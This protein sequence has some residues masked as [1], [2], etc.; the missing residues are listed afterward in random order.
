MDPFL[1][2][3]CGLII[4]LV[5]L[6]LGAH[7]G[8]AL[9]VSGFLGLWYV[10][11]F[12]RAFIM[13]VSSIYGKV[14]GTALVTLPL[15][16]LVGFLASGGGISENIYKSLDMMIGRFKSGLG[17]ATVGAC[18]A[19]GTVCGS[20]LVTAA[21]FAKISAPEMRR[22][23][24]S[25]GLAY[26]I[27]AASGSIGM[28]IPP[29]I[30]AI[31]YGMLSGVS[32]GKL[33]IAG[34]V[35]G[36]LWAVLFSITIPIVARV[37]PTSIVTTDEDIPTYTLWEK[38]KSL[39]LWWPVFASGAIIFGGI[40]GGVFTP[41]EASAVAAF[42]L[43]VYYLYR[44]LFSK[45][46]AE[47]SG[48]EKFD[49]LKEILTNTATTSAMIFFVF[50]AATIFSHFALMT[51]LASKLMTFVI[52]LKL[53]KLSLIIFF[54]VIYLLLG[55]LM[56][57]ISMLCITISLFNPIIAKAGIDPIWYAIV[58][59]LAIEV[60]F[61][62]PPFGINLYSVLGVAEKDVDIKDLIVGSFPFFIA[63]MISLVLILAFPVLATF[64]PS[65]LG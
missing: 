5:L 15:F 42:V 16:V 44:S 18:T 11:G 48:K 26:G 46:G 56:D 6:A 40:Y 39:Q 54:A 13:S 59:I 34:I 8:I 57:S 24:Y 33:L 9:A 1:I 17:I 47:K 60:G 32:I 23:G 35:P 43:F 31:V 22:R 58:V 55:C 25:K 4:L 45:A 38:I 61:I 27:C 20:S 3:L 65:L 28:L 53:S 7:V 2:G 12:D 51:G 41:T 37:S 19:F 29:S 62:T 30:L 50:G 21:V 49:E 63:E 64:L 36:L 52:G 10:L 14:S